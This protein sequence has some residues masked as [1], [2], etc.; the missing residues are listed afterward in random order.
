MRFYRILIIVIYSIVYAYSCYK[1]IV[2]PDKT[3]WG[4][5]CALVFGILAILTIPIFIKYQ[6]K[7]SENNQE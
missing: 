5:I 7:K 3:I 6:K 2:E 1:T 4:Y